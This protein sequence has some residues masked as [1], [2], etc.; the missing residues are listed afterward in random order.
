MNKTIKGKVSYYYNVS[1]STSQCWVGFDV[2]LDLIKDSPIWLIELT[3]DVRQ[4]YATD[5]DAY[6][7][8]KKLL[9]MICASGCF[10]YRDGNPTNLIEYSNILILD[11]DWD[12]PDPTEIEAFRQQLIR[13]ATPLHIYAIWKSPAKGLKVAMIH[14]NRESALHTELFNQVKEQLYPRI[15]Q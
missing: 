8:K 11:F 3:N 1:D 6:K 7:E 9:P 2:V 14:S 4:L 5:N 10:K 12:I 15:P 13:Y